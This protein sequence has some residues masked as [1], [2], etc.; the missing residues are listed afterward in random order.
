MYYFLCDCKPCTSNQSLN[1]ILCP[2]QNCGQG[3]PV[4]QQV[5]DY[6]QGLAVKFLDWREQRNENYKEVNNFLFIFRVMY[7]SFITC[8]ELFTSF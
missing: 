6:V 8:I 2:N 4:K 5:Y 1:V 3:I 7:V